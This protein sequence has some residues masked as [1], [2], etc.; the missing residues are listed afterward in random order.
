[1][2]TWQLREMALEESEWCVT[3]GLLCKEY[4]QLLLIVR[5]SKHGSI[6][7]DR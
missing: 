3:M 5:N 2:S 1:M 6:K 7:H 4:I